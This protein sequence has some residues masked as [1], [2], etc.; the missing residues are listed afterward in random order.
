MDFHADLLWRH[1][2]M[3]T[4]N[5]HS[6]F[7]WHMTVQTYPHRCIWNTRLWSSIWQSIAPM[8]M[9]L[10]MAANYHNGQRTWADSAQLC[11][12]GPTACKAIK[13]SALFYCDNLGL[14]AAL[15]KSSCK[16]KL[17]MQLLQVLSFFIAHHDIYSTSTHIA[18]ALNIPADHLS[19]FNVSSFFL[20]LHYPCHY[21]SCCQ[22]PSQTGHPHSSGSCLLI[23]WQGY[24][25]TYP[26]QGINVP[27][28]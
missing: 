7:R 19:K 8:E 18:G 16:D 15:N 21:F 24:A 1:T 28:L 4:W 13:Q 5:G 12:I 14:V 25:T 20:Q 27:V 17:V 6:L 26:C 3:T 11:R 23:P 9:A 2:F 22:Q 10:G